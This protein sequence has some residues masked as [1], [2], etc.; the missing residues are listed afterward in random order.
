MLPIKVGGVDPSHY[1]G[2]TLSWFPVVGSGND[3]APYD[4]DDDEWDLGEWQDDT[5]A[6][7]RLRKWEVCPINLPG[8]CIWLH[9]LFLS[10][11]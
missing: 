11:E 7:G 3:D 8:R 6:A 9:V 5:Y 10:W 4:D 1:Q 2:D